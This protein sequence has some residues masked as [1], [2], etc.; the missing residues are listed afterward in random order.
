MSRPTSPFRA[1]SL[2][3]ALV[4]L[5]TALA[6]PIPVAGAPN[7]VRLVVT[8]QPGTP[9]AVAERL[10]ANGGSVVERIEQLNVRVVN[11]PAA[12]AEHARGRWAAAGEVAEVE[13]DGLV[14]ADWVPPDPLWDYQWEQRQVRAPKAWSV[15]RGEGSTIVAVVDTG[16][17]LNHPDLSARLVSGYDFVNLDAKPNDDNGHGTSVAG[18]VAASTNSLGVAGMCMRCRVMPV[19]ALDAN[20]I[21]WWSVA[22]RAIIWAADHHADV[23]NMS[24]GGPTGG[25]TLASAVAYARSRGVVMVGAAGNDGLRAKFFP[26]A[27][28]GVISV[29]ASSDR[30]LRFAWSNYS[31]NWVDMAAPGCTW[32]T[33]RVSGYGGFCGTSAA[34]PVVSGIAA[35]VESA[36]PSLSGA[37][38]E[39]ILSLATIQTPWNFTRFGRIDAY[40]AV[41]R[42][43]HGRRPSMPQLLPAAP[44]LN[45]AAEVTFLAGAHAGYRFESS[46]AIIHGTGLVLDGTAIAHTSKRAT[47][48]G[49]G[50][51]NWY[52]MVD[53][54]LD[55]YWVPE[56]S[57][58]FQTPQP[59]PIPSPTPPPTP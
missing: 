51:T 17:Q 21:G 1:A 50:S 15:E 32:T 19:K 56:S 5:A 3:A 23:I 37:Q 57:T 46:G 10:A 45:P 25:S 41:Y 22:A 47:M 42:A 58:V 11:V 2:L 8:F 35:L 16:V 43:L 29:A 33:K 48:P 53:G 30:D 7:M 59:T 40:K 34:T 39:S 55:G 54:G 13:T 12:A 31:P 14:T 27:F 6:V 38:I 36:K 9:A 52:Y 20:G 28:P 4:L 24:F 44:L 18:I 26:A 49:R